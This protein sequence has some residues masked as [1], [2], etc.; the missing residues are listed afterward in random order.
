MKK[1]FGVFIFSL[2]ASLQS[3]PSCPEGMVHI[4]NGNFCIDRYE[5]PNQFGAQPDFALTAFQAEALCQGVEKRL[6]T[7][8][9]W[10]SACKGPKNL[11]YGYG[12]SWQKAACNDNVSS[13]YIPVDWSRMSDP[14]EW[15]K[16]ARTLYKG[17]PSGSKDACYTD[18]NDYYVY[19][20]IGN[21]REWVKDPLG[22]GGY[23]FESSF[24]YGTM[25]GPQGCGFV[26]RNHSPKFAS[27]EVGARCCKDAN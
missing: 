5:W 7:H 16:Y 14:V 2:W 11:S 20:M 17:V 21:V 27:Y 8:N 23:A 10:V 25:A 1:L 15:K 12:S 6:C 22:N 4:Q 13:K 3:S 9:E 26:V 18:E 24:W 19:D